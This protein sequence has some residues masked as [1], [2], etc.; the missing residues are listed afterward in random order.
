MNK[1]SILAA[2][3]ALAVAIAGCI[4]YRVGRLNEAINVLWVPKEH[5]MLAG[6]MQRIELSLSQRGRWD[7]SSRRSRL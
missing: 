2:G 4:G 7:G 1:A 3:A 6:S 5:V